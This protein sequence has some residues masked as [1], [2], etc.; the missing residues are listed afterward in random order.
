MGFEVA[1]VALSPFSSD[2]FPDPRKLQILVTNAASSIFWG[3]QG[4]ILMN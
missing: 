2:F 3:E 1:Q 4:D